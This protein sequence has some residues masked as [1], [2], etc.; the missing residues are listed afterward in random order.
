MPLSKEDIRKIELKIQQKDIYST[1]ETAKILGVFP[2]S[3]INWISKGHLI[4][5][6]TPGGHRRI[7]KEELLKFVRTHNFH[8]GVGEKHKTKVLIV[9]DDRDAANLCMNILGKD[10]YEIKTVENGFYAGIVQEYKPDIVI[11]DI[12]LPDIDGEQVCRFIRKDKNLRKTKIIA[13]SAIS[14]ESKIK[15]LYQSGID[16]FVG[17]PYE[18][19]EFEKKFEH[20]VQDAA[21]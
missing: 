15:S 14:D 4:C 8:R 17:K 16:D 19:K 3:V 1:Q 20:L 2:T 12:M 7:P 9:E 10:K 13:V 21:A 18:I 11:L 5:F 6:K